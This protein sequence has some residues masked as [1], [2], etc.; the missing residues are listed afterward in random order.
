[1]ITVFNRKELHLTYDMN[2]RV[3]ICDILRANN[4]AYYT[5]T[6]NTT[7]S[8]FGHSRRADYGTLGLNTDYMYEYHIYV[9]KKDYDT[10]LY[11][12][13]NNR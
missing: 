12:I 11:L 9:H 6:V 2:E 3:R 1:M 10:A 8:S 4:I 13:H 5:K 7:A